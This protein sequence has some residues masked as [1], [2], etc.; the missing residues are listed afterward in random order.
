LSYILRT[1]EQ[2]F[3]ERLNGI[4]E[5]LNE[6]ASEASHFGYSIEIDC[7]EDQTFGIPRPQVFNATGAKAIKCPNPPQGTL[8]HIRGTA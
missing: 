4:V 2:E 1:T 5:Q 7:V 3:A 6:L 8:G